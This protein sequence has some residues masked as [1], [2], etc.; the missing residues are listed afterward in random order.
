MIK[1]ATQCGSR[2]VQAVPW[3]ELC[4]SEPDAAVHTQEDNAKKQCQVGAVFASQMQRSKA[5]ASAR[6]IG[7]DSL[8]SLQVLLSPYEDITGDAMHSPSSCHSTVLANQRRAFNA[9]GGEV[10]C[11]ARSWIAEC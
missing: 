2:Q 9:V 5:T 10:R 8:F 7:Y 3:H 11:G 4:V 1:G 6:G